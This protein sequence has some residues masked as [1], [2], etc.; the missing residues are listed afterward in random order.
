[1]SAHLLASSTTAGEPPRGIAGPVEAAVVKVRDGDTVEVEAFVWP[2]QTVHTAVR[3]RGVDAPELKAK[4]DGEREAAEAAR[5]RLVALLQT[6]RVKLTDIEG[7][8]YF[9]RVL[10]D[11]STQDVPDIAA[12]LRR[13]GLVGA[14]GG[15]KR[16]DWCDGTAPGADA[17]LMERLLGRG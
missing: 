8:K 14:Y 9:G 3:L 10:A 4:C 13:E 5:A 2:M 1:M 15:G 7:D 11:L 16:R 6:G 12:T 17:G